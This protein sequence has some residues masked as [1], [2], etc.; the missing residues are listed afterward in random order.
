MLDT[1]YSTPGTERK[2]SAPNILSQVSVNAAHSYRQN[3]VTTADPH[4][5]ILVA[6]DRAIAGCRQQ[7]LEM[8]WRAI[9]ELIGGLNMDAG[10]IA[11]DLLGIYLY[12]VEIARKGQY[13]DAANILQDLRD[14]WA[15][16]RS[17]SSP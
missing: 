17:T 15:A 3:S 2:S 9:Q 4:K 13:E 16:V 14:T 10:A 12:C 7:D 1:R 11:R 8:S 5:L 6:Y